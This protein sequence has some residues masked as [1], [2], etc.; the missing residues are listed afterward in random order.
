MK[1]AS[2]LT[3]LSEENLALAAQT[4]VESITI[5]YQG[6]TLEDWK[7]AVDLIRSY[8]MEIAAVE[9]AI[10]MENI[11]RGSEGR[12]DEIDGIMAF[13]YYEGIGDSRSLLQLHGRNRLGSD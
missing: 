3:P 10:A 8:G 9:D 5:R 6:P 4:G 2:V 11:I 7:P 13:T 12:D 1:L